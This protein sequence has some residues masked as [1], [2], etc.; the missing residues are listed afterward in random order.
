MYPQKVLQ[1]VPNLERPFDFFILYLL[2][3]A[4]RNPQKIRYGLLGHALG[5]S[6]GF[7]VF[8]HPLHLPAARYGRF[9]S[10]LLPRHPPP[11]PCISPK[12]GGSYCRLKFECIPG[13]R[14]PGQQRAPAMG[15]SVFGLSLLSP[16]DRIKGKGEY[17]W[18]IQL[19]T[20]PLKF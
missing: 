11:V 12:E 5:L 13:G 14:C 9:F 17:L 3:M 4:Q 8:S 15:G 1:G 2:V 7:Q 20:K 18:T 16:C 10:I 19:P 6:G